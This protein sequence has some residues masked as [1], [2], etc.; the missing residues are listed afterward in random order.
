MKILVRNRN[1]PISF[2]WQSISHFLHSRNHL[3][4]KLLHGYYAVNQIVFRGRSLFATP[5]KIEVQY[6]VVLFVSIYHPLD[7]QKLSKPNFF[8]E[9]NCQMEPKSP[10]ALHSKIYTEIRHHERYIQK[11]KALHSKQNNNNQNGSLYTEQP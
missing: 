3:Q 9:L 11:P 6:S 10:E 4:L 2:P 1:R 8:V 7:L 5:V